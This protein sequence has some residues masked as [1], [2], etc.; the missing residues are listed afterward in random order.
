MTFLGPE[1]HN[2]YNFSVGRGHNLVN[3]RFIFIFILTF[4]SCF[5]L[6]KTFH[7]FKYTVILTSASQ[8][9]YFVTKE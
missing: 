7:F 8:L 2:N 6:I 5:A 4:K 1:K 3:I 9:D